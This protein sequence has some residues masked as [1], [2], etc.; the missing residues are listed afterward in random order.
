WILLCH[1]SFLSLLFHIQL[2]NLL[3]LTIFLN[4]YN[5]IA[6]FSFI[7]KYVFQYFY[8]LLISNKQT[9]GDYKLAD[10][11]L[12]FAKCSFLLF[13]FLIQLSLKFMLLEIFFQFVNVY[14]LIS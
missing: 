13:I 3:I 8:L 14:I 11:I 1:L 5:F 7:Q 9:L 6:I 12:N 4:C 10:V 2:T